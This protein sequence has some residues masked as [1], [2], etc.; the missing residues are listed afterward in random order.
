MKLSRSVLCSSYQYCHV[1]WMM[2]GEPAGGIYDLSTGLVEFIGRT[3]KPRGS[4]ELDPA[5]GPPFGFNEV[6]P[7]FLGPVM[8]LRCF[9]SVR[10]LWKLFFSG[11]MCGFS[12]QVF[13]CTAW[14]QACWFSSSSAFLLAS[15][16][17]ALPWFSDI[18][19]LLHVATVS[20][21]W[22]SLGTSSWACSS[23]KINVA[24]I[25]MLSSR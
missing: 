15:P 3:P 9:W 17:P 1:L 8:E 5:F 21:L 25:E 2:I 19:T 18:S 10:G 23:G 4:I 16:P 6:G 11:G 24:V 7:S 12:K 22:F 14:M 13:R 20:C